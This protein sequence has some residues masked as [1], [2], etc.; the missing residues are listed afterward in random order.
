MS[1]KIKAS[2]HGKDLSFFQKVFASLAAGSLGSVVATPCDLVLVRMQADKRPDIPEAERRNYTGVFNA[3]SRIV[4]EEGARGL[5][6]G[7]MATMMRATVLNCWMLVSYDTA[8]E[9]LKKS[10][11]EASDRKVAI[12]SSLV[13]SCFTVVGTLPFDNI[14]TKVQ[15]QKANAEGVKPYSGIADCFTKSIAKEGVTGLWAGLPTFYFRVGP[16][17]II[18]LLVAETLRKKLL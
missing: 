3:F 18:T 17:A 10:M 16:H 9:N 13:S 14:K 1:E 11:P 5:Y 12:Y 15:N 7:A 6:T 4:S 2:N 8:K